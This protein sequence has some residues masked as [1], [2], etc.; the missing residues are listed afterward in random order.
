MTAWFFLTIFAWRALSQ[1]AVVVL[2]SGASAPSLTVAP[3]EVTTLFI[4]GF[5]SGLL[6]H[7]SAPG[8]PL[9]TTLARISVLLEQSVTPVGLPPPPPG[10]L[11]QV[12][13]PLLAIN[14]VNDCSS[15]PTAAP[16]C[17]YSIGITLQIPFELAPI[18]PLSL[19]PPAFAQL[20]VLDNGVRVG[21]ISIQ[22]RADQI[23][24]LRSCDTFV[25]AANCTSSVTP[26]V[27]HADGT[28]VSASAPAKSHE[29]LVF[30]AVGLFPLGDVPRPVSGIPPTSTI[31]VSLPDVIFDFRAN[32]PPSRSS[33]FGSNTSS[34]RFAGLIPGGIGLYQ[35][36]VQLPAIPPGTP[37]CGGQITSN[38]T[39]SFSEGYSFDG[40]GICVVS[41]I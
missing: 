20:V 28:L 25:A 13:V 37:A 3:G 32:A 26:I 22:A 23:H 40:T 41:G 17:A 24:I 1:D 38:L 16:P 34:V 27:T 36:N 29:V 4:A 8:V 10:M 33:T 35:L 19:A 15:P 6:R 21:V 30:Y 9:P 39:V 12:Q 2:G 11:G 5:S 7:A 31:P 14:P 18:N